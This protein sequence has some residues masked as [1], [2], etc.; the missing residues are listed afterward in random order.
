MVDT[1]A[2]ILVVINT[3]LLVIVFFRLQSSASKQDIINVMHWV[4]LGRA[5]ALVESVE[6]VKK[7]NTKYDVEELLGE[8]DNPTA[9]EWIYYLDEHSGYVIAFDNASRVET[10]SAWRS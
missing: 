4:R 1:L 7:G 9:G 2:F 10:V 3:V 8:A 6:K 5:K